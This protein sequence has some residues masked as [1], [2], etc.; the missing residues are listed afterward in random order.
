MIDE[1]EVH[2]RDAC[3]FR[4]RHVPGARH[5]CVG[6]GSARSRSSFATSA[7]AASAAASSDSVSLLVAANLALQRFVQ[8]AE[9]AD[10]LS[11]PAMRD[12][13][14]RETFAKELPCPTYFLGRPNR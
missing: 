4:S 7:R 2:D 14:G 9:C 3:R 13:A 1:V 11:E 12:F 8:L 6:G 5:V 10:I